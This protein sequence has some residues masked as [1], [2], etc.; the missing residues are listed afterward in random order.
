M[1]QGC[2]SSCRPTT[3]GSGRPEEGSG[4]RCP[5]SLLRQRRPH[6]DLYRCWSGTPAR[7]GGVA[8]PVRESC[9]DCGAVIEVSV[10]QFVTPDGEL[11]WSRSIRCHPCGL[12]IEED[13]MGF[14]PES[15]RQQ[16]VATWG[17]WAV[18]LHDGASRTMAVKVLRARLGWDLRQ[19]GDHLRSVTR[20]FWR[21]TEAE[22]R[23]LKHHLTEAGVRADT[24]RC[25]AQE[26]L[27]GVPGT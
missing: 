11:V 6:R 7:G 18:V 19:A 20:T 16:L 25:P 22:A 26:Y 21:G 3:I 8:Q 12:A 2:R 24:V 1:I 5:P 10:G 9:P 14:P 27:S 17:R 4:R 23:W 15:I 13:D